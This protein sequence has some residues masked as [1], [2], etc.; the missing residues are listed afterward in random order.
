MSP[1]MTFASLS[2]LAGL[3]A[4]AARAADTP[5]EFKGCLANETT[6]I[7]TVE[8]VTAGMNVTRGT[9]DLVG[10]PADKMLHDCRTLWI[11]S[12]TG[13]EFTNRCVNI[14]KDGDKH[15]T[16]AT[17]SP[18][19]FQ[20]KFVS[21]SGKYAGISGAGTAEVTTPYPR[22]KNVSASCYQ[23]R[24]TYTLKQ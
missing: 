5:F 12:K 11:A 9:M 17:G 10:A 15:I 20:W 21:G 24:G 2:L 1:A 22:A 13:V 8:G 4:S 14:D 23:G 7:D 6:I 19:S 3:T 16:M 18:K